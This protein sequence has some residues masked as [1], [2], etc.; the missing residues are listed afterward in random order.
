MILDHVTQGSSLLIVAS[1]GAN[2]FVLSHRNLDMIDVFLIPQRFEDG[3]G[4]THNQE[5][6]DGF[7]A[8]IVIDAKNLALIDDLHQSV[9][10]GAGAGQVPAQWLFHNEA[11]LWSLTWHGNESSI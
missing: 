8:E 4:K 7:L 11:C 1:T 5:I 3:I 9:I 6:L 2:A 10:N